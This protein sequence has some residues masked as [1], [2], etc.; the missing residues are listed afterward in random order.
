[1]H[2][3]QK[4]FFISLSSV[5]AFFAIFTF[6]FLRV[7]F[8]HLIF[9]NEKDYINQKFNNRLQVRGTKIVQCTFVNCVY[10]GNSSHGGAL[11]IQY[12]NLYLDSSVFIS[13]SAFYS[14]AVEISATKNVTVSNNVF[15]NNS[16]FRFG[17]MFL[18]GP[19][20]SNFI[21]IQKNNFTKNK[22]TRWI[23]AIRLHLFNG[24]MS[25]CVFSQNTSPFFG[26]LFDFSSFL[27]RRD[28][29]RLNFYNNTG[30]Y[31]GY[32]TYRHSA[33]GYFKMCNFY[34][35]RNVKEKRGRSF[36]V[37]SNWA[38][39]TLENCCFEGSMDQEIFIYFQGSSKVDVKSSTKFN[40]GLPK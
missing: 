10:P 6:S 13:N 12:G 28:F 25:D 30:D 23:G 29:T 36:Y 8:S 17:A 21:E 2:N 9:R 27:L 38:I 19:E 11:M 20:S 32:T 7:N 5:L 24:S 4:I 3:F 40:L 22:A 1:M 35:N 26:A 15:M 33:V 14:G 18:D 34:G 16:A 31:A 37:F 39:E